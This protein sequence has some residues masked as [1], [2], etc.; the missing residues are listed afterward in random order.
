M[1][2]FDKSHVRPFEVQ[3]ASLSRPQAPL[4]KSVR[5]VQRLLS[6]GGLQLEV[7]LPA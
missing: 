6:L 2:S 4:H 1:E 7:F 5:R 3:I